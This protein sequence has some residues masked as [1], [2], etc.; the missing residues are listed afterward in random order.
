MWASILAGMVVLA[1]LPL[2]TSEN[3]FSVENK[4]L[5]NAGNLILFDTI[6]HTHTPILTD[7]DVGWVAFSHG[8]RIAFAERGVSSDG[9]EIFDLETGELTKLAMPF[10][11]Q[12]SDIRY[13]PISWNP[14]G[15]Y[16]AYLA[17][18]ADMLPQLYIWD[19]EQS[20][21]IT[22]KRDER[23]VLFGSR[24][25]WGPDGQLAFSTNANIYLWY[26][27]KPIEI[28]PG[29]REA[30]PTWNADGRLAFLQD[31]QVVV[32]DG[33]SS[34]RRVRPDLIHPLPTLRDI[35]S[36]LILY[37]WAAPMWTSRWD[38]CWYPVAHPIMDWR[39]CYTWDGNEVTQPESR[40]TDVHSYA[41]QRQR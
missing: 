35:Q 22:P 14:D 8:G 39:K 7:K 11:P 18:A 6:T 26:G 24:F 1:V 4:L 5:Y 25:A 31:G 23:I 29:I 13:V 30:Q 28:S 19:G 21:N 12:R 3:E 34:L 40:T 9:I 33:V 32:W 37:Y 20:F 38:V 17:E 27:D 36:K 2:S 15:E 16:L 10:S 41:P